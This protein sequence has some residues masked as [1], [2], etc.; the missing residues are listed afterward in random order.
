MKQRDE[1][2]KESGIY[3]N[4]ELYVYT[5]PFPQNSVANIHS[6]FFEH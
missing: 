5:S 2:E 3:I 1:C 6:I 4:A